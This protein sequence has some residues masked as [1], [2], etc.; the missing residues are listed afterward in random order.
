MLQAQW[1]KP[2]FSPFTTE[3]PLV[4][5]SYRE[6][7]PTHLHQRREVKEAGRW[8]S[9]QSVRYSRCR[10]SFCSALFPLLRQKSPPPRM[11]VALGVL[12][13]WQKSSGVSPLATTHPW[14]TREASSKRCWRE[15]AA[16]AG[17]V[18]GQE[19]VIRLVHGMGSGARSGM[20]TRERRSLAMCF[21]EAA[22]RASLPVPQGAVRCGI[23]APTSGSQQ[24]I[25]MLHK[26]F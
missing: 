15:P 19:T 20:F 21:R 2:L 12:A 16:H 22:L 5:S 3:I 6:P 13:N 25:R 4:T 14:T 1:L 9:R 18:G 24:A 10:C 17:P 7:S 11:A 23:P 8:A 26:A